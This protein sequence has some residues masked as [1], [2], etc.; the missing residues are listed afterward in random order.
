LVL[1]RSPWIE[2]DPTL[3]ESRFKSEADKTLILNLKKKKSQF[4][5]VFIFFY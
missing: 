5:L 2:K 4:F 3:G 1:N